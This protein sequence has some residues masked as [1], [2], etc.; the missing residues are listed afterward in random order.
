MASGQSAGL[1]DGDHSAFLKHLQG[2][3]L[4][5]QDAHLGR[6]TGPN[7]DRGRRGQA[8]CT[9][10]GDDQHGHAC[11]QGEAKGGVRAKGKPN[12]NCQNG[13]DYH[14]WNEPL[15]D[16]VDHALN[17]QLGALSLLDHLND[18][19]QHRIAAD[20]LCPEGQRPGAIDSCPD[21]FRT[22]SLFNRHRFPGDHALINI[23]RAGQHDPV[24]GNLFARTH[25]NDIAHNDILD[26]AF[27]DRAIPFHPCG[28]GLQADELANGLTGAAL[29]ARLQQTTQKDQ[30]DNDGSCLVIDIGGAFGQ[31]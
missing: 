8:H 27:N 2:V 31:S 19:R 9:G 5:E 13:N 28:F 22:F 26:G 10:A 6:P 12:G 3:A 18:L 4:A 15:G 24:D 23:G 16:P 30:H 29:R 7:H 21:N 20:F 14:R 25:M 11:H 17:G 1:V